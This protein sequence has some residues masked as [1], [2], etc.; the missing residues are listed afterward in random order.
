MSRQPTWDTA[1][2]LQGEMFRE[3]AAIGGL[4]VQL[5]YFR[6]LNECR[7]SRWVSDGA[8]ARRPDGAHRLPRRPHA[9]PQGACSMRAPST[10]SARSR[11]WSLSAMPWRRRSTTSRGGGRARP[12]RRAG[13]HVPGG[14]RSDRRAGV[15]R[16]RAA[17]ARR[18]LPF[19]SR[20]RARVGRVAAR[21]GGL[22]GRRRQGTDGSTRR[23]RR[24]S[25]SRR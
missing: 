1:C 24:A 22:C 18:L 19:R 6:G 23:G 20:R 2:K 10:T 3:A 25:C 8:G 4:D 15:P 5:V 9:D 16:D 21:G 17:D 11:R 12:A 13:L 14:P 7:S